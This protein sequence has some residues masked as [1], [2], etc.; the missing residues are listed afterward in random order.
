MGAP[1]LIGAGVGALGSALTGNNPLKGALLGGSLGSGY[2]GIQSLLQ[3]GSFMQGAVP[4]MAETVKPAAMANIAVGG[5]ATLPSYAAPIGMA[6]T[7]DLA[8]NAT[9]NAA[10]QAGAVSEFAPALLSVA[11][12]A[13]GLTA[14]ATS[15]PMMQQLGYTLDEIKGMLPEL[16]SQN[17][18]NAI[19]AANVARQYMQQPRPQAPAGGIS[20]GNPPSATAVQELIGQMKPQQRKRIS[21]LV[22]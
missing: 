17:V 3:G 14:A 11:P 9:I 1:A 16:S 20:R 2:G 18:G 22:G 6:N 12:E 15:V 5:G 8:T 21:L 13:G 19:G 10:N 4:F 7:F